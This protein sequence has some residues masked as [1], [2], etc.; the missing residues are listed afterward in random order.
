MLG[1]DFF[2]FAAYQT[3]GGLPAGG[4]VDGVVIIVCVLV[5]VELLGV[6]DG[7][8]VRDGDVLGTAVRAAAAGCAGDEVLA[9]ENFLHLLNSGK[10]RFVQR[11][12]IRHERNIVLHLLHAAHAGEHHQHA[13][14]AR[15]E[16]QGIA[17]RAAAVQRVQNSLRLL[18]QH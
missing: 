16:A 15:G 9:A 17:C 5:V 6:H 1:T 12:K 3:V 13:G 10:F 4:G 11:L 18:R 7:E 14:E 2:A 8:Q